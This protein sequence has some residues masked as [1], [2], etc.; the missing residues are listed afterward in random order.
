MTP[1]LLFT[2]KRIFP[3]KKRELFFEIMF[4]RSGLLGN[5]G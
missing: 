2:L 3:F 4:S 5:T 1:C